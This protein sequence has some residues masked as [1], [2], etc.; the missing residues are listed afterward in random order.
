M[1]DTILNDFF[2]AIGGTDFLISIV[3]FFI[4]FLII[5]LLLE[6]ILE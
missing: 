1:L 6:N 3:G 5:M 2:V 4:A